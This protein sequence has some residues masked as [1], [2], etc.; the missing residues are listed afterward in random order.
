LDKSKIATSYLLN[1]L[2]SLSIFVPLWRPE[3]FRNFVGGD[4]DRIIER[5]VVKTDDVVNFLN[6]YA[7]VVP[8]NIKISEFF[9]IIPRYLLS[10]DNMVAQQVINILKKI[11]N[12]NRIVDINELD[13]IDESNVSGSIYHF[14]PEDSLLICQKIFGSPLLNKIV[15]FELRKKKKEELINRF[16]QAQENS[17]NSF[18]KFEELIACV[19]LERTANKFI[20]RKLYGSDPLFSFTDF[21][22]DSQERTN[23]F[24]CTNIFNFNV[25][26]LA[27]ENSKTYDSFAFVKFNNNYY[28][29]S[30]QVTTSNRHSVAEAG[31]DY[32]L[33]LLNKKVR[34]EN[35]L[36]DTTNVSV[37]HIFIT[38]DSNVNSFTIENRHGNY[39]SLDS[40]KKKNINVFVLGYK[41][42]K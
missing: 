42:K 22:L 35:D 28:L 20:F 2:S 3:E 14:I 23:S 16:L 6:E 30:I 36:L 37:Y 8:Q 7:Q 34:I 15:N 12:R 26:Y 13:K 18:K 33:N 38:L 41:I 40:L 10:S 5:E 29:L 1:N 25:L 19:L 39:Y 31:L 17:E 21:T 27:S 9:G 4:F 11:R 24:V 32:L